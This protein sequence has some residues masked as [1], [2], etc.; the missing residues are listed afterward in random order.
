MG[1]IC[2]TVSVNLK[3]LCNWW[4]DSQVVFGIELPV[5]AITHNSRDW[6]PSVCIVCKVCIVLKKF[7]WKSV[8]RISDFTLGGTDSCKNFHKY[9]TYPRNLYQLSLTVMCL[10]R[11]DSGTVMS[12]A[13][14]FLLVQS[15]RNL[16]TSLSSR[17]ITAK[18]V[19]L[20][21]PY[22]V[23]CSSSTSS[24]FW[25]VA[26]VT[27]CVRWLLMQGLMCNLYKYLLCYVGIPYGS[28]THASIEAEL[29]EF[30]IEYFARE[31]RFPSILCQHG[32]L[33]W[34][35]ILTSTQFQDSQ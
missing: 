6:L 14:R 11:N 18:P 26:M 4:L 21:P 15:W 32:N 8:Y 34:V 30:F 20:G 17:S 33:C 29:K 25:N 5:Y 7:A 16:E 10:S 2:V 23:W 35:L 1:W 22:I 27:L 19:M 28:K 9:R 24:I 12:L 13:S 3:Y 31:Y